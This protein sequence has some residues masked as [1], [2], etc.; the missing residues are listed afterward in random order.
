MKLLEDM[1]EPELRELMNATCRA[2][3]DTAKRRDVEPPLF[4]VVLF[5]DPKI[6]Q[7]ASNGTRSDII[8]AMRETADR[9]ERCD[10]VT[11]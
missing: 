2:I 3:L 1:T 6:A 7:Y 11:R 9:L 10:D 8:A 5:N 4:V